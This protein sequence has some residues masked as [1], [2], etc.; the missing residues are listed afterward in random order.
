MP[1]FSLGLLGCGGGCECCSVTFCLACSGTPISGATITVTTDS[2][3]PSGTTNSSGCVSLAIPAAGSYTVTIESETCASDPMVYTMSLACTDTYNID[4][5]SCPETVCVYGCGDTPLA[6][7]QVQFLDAEGG[8]A[9][10]TPT[11]CEGY[12][13]SNGCWTVALG[14]SDPVD[15]IATATYDGTEATQTFSGCNNTLDFYNFCATFTGCADE[16][17]V[18]VDIYLNDI[19]EETDSSGMAC[20][21]TAAGTFSFSYD[22]YRFEPVSTTVN[23]ADGCIVTPTLTVESGYGCCT[24]CNE[25][26]CNTLTLVDSILGTCTL[27]LSGSNPCPGSG[28]PNTF[29]GYLSVSYPGYCGCPASTALV[30]FQYTCPAGGE[31]GYPELSVAVLGCVTGACEAGYCPGDCE[32]GSFLPVTATLV[33]TECDPLETVFS[34]QVGCACYPGVNPTCACEGSSGGAVSNFLSVWG[35]SPTSVT[36]TITDECA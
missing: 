25:P 21:F 24:G 17:I 12:T 15:Y 31:G 11:N 29:N 6:D 33:S 23:V 30:C 34:G 36:W 19:L 13:G 2:G 28:G 14:V 4:C 32:S 26:V 20:W 27:T 22:I 7:V 8:P 18:G 9:C 16:P 35:T 3:S 1:A 10:S 5:C